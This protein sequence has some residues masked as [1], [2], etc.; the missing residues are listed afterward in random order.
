MEPKY[1]IFAWILL[2][3]KILITENL[4]A[5]GWPLTNRRAPFALPR[6]KQDPTYVCTA[7]LPKRFGIRCW[8][9]KTL[10]PPKPTSAFSP[11]LHIGGS[12]R[13]PHSQRTVG[14][15][16]MMCLSSSYRTFGRNGTVEF[17]RGTHLLW[18]RWQPCLERPLLVSGEHFHFR[19]KL[20]FM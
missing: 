4:A 16:S 15:T 8:R 3:N 11:T 10:L 12:L 7:L 2:Q 9:R 13:L 14:M 17:F 20:W 19:F 18:I 1:K 5:R 6:W